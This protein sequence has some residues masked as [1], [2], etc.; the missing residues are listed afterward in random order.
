MVAVIS[1]SLP[2]DLVKKVDRAVEQYG[3]RSRSDLIKPRSRHS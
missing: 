2:D 1:V 3:Y